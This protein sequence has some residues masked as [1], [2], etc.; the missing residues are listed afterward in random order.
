MTPDQAASLRKTHSSLHAAKHLAGEK[1]F[2]QTKRA[3]LSFRLPAV[4]GRIH[5]EARMKKQRRTK[6]VHEGRYLAEVD[7]ELLV[8]SMTHT[9]SMMCVRR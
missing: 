3:A 5:E 6:L 1:C 8:M 7:V 2:G 9:S 4:A